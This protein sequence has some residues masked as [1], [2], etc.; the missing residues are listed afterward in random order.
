MRRSV[1]EGAGKA[2]KDLQ[3]ASTQHISHTHC[4]VVVRCDPTQLH[5]ITLTE[6]C[7]KSVPTDFSA[8]C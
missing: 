5:S 8:A 6:S 1:S 2:G 3:T 7:G 4:Y